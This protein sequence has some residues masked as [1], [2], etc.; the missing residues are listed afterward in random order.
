MCALL[1]NLAKQESA[2]SKV[3]CR[4]AVSLRPIGDRL[5]RTEPIIN[6]PIMFVAQPNLFRPCDSQYWLFQVDITPFLPHTIRRRNTQHHA[7]RCFPRR[8]PHS[9]LQLVYL[10]QPPSLCILQHKKNNGEDASIR[11]SPFCVHPN[12]R[13]GRLKQQHRAYAR[14][15]A[16][17]IVSGKYGHW[18]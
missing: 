12:H 5:P 17:G 16:S 11:G 18:T 9:Q 3:L 1:Q 4:Q 10:W 13:P 14:D 7:H 6:L 2:R 15:C 8:A